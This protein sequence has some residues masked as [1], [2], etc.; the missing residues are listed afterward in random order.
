HGVAWG[1]DVY[2]GNTGATDSNNYGPYQDYTYFYTGWKA[3]V[4]AGA[5]VIN[6]SW[7]TNPRIINTVP[8]KGPD[9]GNTTEHM[10]VDT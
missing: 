10:P 6:N 3:M 8:T 2:L 9:G 1:A 5:Q 7:G 4:D